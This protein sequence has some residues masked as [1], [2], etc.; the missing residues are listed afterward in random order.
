MEGLGGEAPDL[1]AHTPSAQLDGGRAVQ[2][3]FIQN[4]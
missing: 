4:H 2:V 1:R 3:S